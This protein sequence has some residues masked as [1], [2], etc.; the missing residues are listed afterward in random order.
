MTARQST[1]HAMYA[2]Y[3][4]DV[5]RFAFWLSGSEADAK[6]LTA[7]TFVRAFTGTTEPREETVKS[8]LFTIA[9]NLH[10]KQWHRAQR[11]GPFPA[12]TPDPIVPPDDTAAAR[13]DLQRALAAVQALPEPDR[14]ALLLRAESGLAYEEIAAITGLTVTAAKVKIFRARARLAA[15]LKPTT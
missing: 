2:K 6:D 15:Q 12:A 5:Y 3:A 14:T 8:Y 9:R 7:E 11:Q 4:G 1:F 10:R 13:D